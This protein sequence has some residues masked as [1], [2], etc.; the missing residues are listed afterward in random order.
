MALQLRIHI[1]RHQ[2]R[3]QAKTRL[4]RAQHARLAEHV[5]VQQARGEAQI[6]G[7]AVVQLR[8]DPRGDLAVGGAEE[9]GA[10]G[11]GGG[12]GGGE[13]AAGCG[14][15]TRGEVEEG[16]RGGGFEGA[17]GV[18]GLWWGEG[19]KGSAVVVAGSGAVW[20]G[21]EGWEGTAEVDGRDGGQGRGGAARK[22]RQTDRQTGRQTDRQADRQTGRQ[23]DLP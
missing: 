3:H 19:G 14:G 13:E 6:G 23:T 4:P 21:G 9:G 15:G 7:P 18:D 22:D 8:H 1:Q 2:P 5:P 17:E 10:A 20:I 11:E 16:G 12:E